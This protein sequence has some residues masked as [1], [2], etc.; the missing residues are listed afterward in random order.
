[1][2]VLYFETSS[3]RIR[4]AAKDPS[5]SYNKFQARISEANK[6]CKYSSS[7]PGTLNLYKTDVKKLE[8]VSN[9]EQESAWPVFFETQAYNF[10]I[11]ILDAKS[12]TNP[13]LVHPSK[14]VED[15]FNSIESKDCYLL[16]G[17]INFLNEPG[18]FSL[19]FVYEG[20]DG[21][22]H[23]EYFD[24]DVVS[25]KLDT[26][27]DL[28]TIIQELR[29]EYG[30]L[31]FRYLSLTFQ[32]YSI[33]NDAKNDLI[34]LSIFKQ[35]I[36]KYILAVRYVLHA[37]HNKDYCKEEWRKPDRIRIWAPQLIEKFANDYSKDANE[38]LHKFY[39]TEY[40]EN[41]T[42]TKENR[43]VKYSLDRILERLKRLFEE[44]Q[45][46][47]V[48]ENELN[49]LKSNLIELD[50][51][52]R[53]SFWKGVGRFDG[54][55]QE[56][57]I[58][59]QRSGYAQ[60]YRYWIMLQN[61]LDL[62]DGLKNIG[63]GVKQIWKLYELWCFLKIKSIVC[64]LLQIDSRN[65][66]DCKYINDKSHN[67]MKLFEDGD[68]SGTLELTNK[69]NGDRIEIGYQYSYRR[70]S[71][72]DEMTSMTVEQKPDIV[73][74]IIKNNGFVMTYLFD[75]KY[76]V[77][78]DEENG[79]IEHGDFP[80][81]DTLNQMHRYRDAIYFG[82]K[83]KYN[84]AKEVI[85]GYILFPGRL[86]EKKILEG[87]EPPYYIKSIRDVNI[88]A[89]P[90]LPNEESGL[91]LKEHL[92]KIIL[93]DS[94]F[95]QI[96]DS[97]PQKGLKYLADNGGVAMVMMENYENRRNS[98]IEGRIAIPIKMD[99][100]GKKLLENANTLSYVLF[101]TRNKESNKHLFR[102]KNSPCILMKNDE[103]IK[104]YYKVQN[105]AEIYIGVE[106]MMEETNSENLDPSKDNVPYGEDNFRY[107]AQY[108]EI[109]QLKR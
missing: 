57:M 47:K 67:T 16:C 44:V 26:K 91:L 58:L 38:A 41:T 62:T 18:R 95:D 74:N 60:V 83:E 68:L 103:K 71:D 23:H 2:E 43:F 52:Q 97:V 79:E 98:F 25:P 88:G 92:R 32:Q 22:K 65:P 56:S 4:V 69:E 107:D 42:D 48:S 104:N 102:I 51:L 84:F 101:H 76:R 89:F 36:E 9:F 29:N 80:E 37:P 1:M 78:G 30:D 5:F 13:Y 72:R 17:A 50:S 85:G 21:I 24:F 28:N 73:M 55:R 6:Y 99:I 7:K 40:V 106:L 82:N 105:K 75:A 27:N 109:Q 12:R 59:Q 19:Q 108:I 8:L 53:N 63:I 15:L 49:S 90:L 11:E 94:V 81:D 64:E 77:K 35:I 70:N 45:K 96:K 54:F 20:K 14:D 46:Y 33:G 31:V 93:G 86:N 3:Y 39:R 61:G 34:W 87:T 100:N 10:T 66:E